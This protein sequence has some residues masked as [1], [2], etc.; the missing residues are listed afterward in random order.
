MVMGRSVCSQA[1]GLAHRAKIGQRPHFSFSFPSGWEFLNAFSSIS[2][3]STSGLVS[4]I[5]LFGR[6]CVRLEFE[7]TLHSGDSSFVSFF[8][9]VRENLQNEGGSQHV[10]DG[11]GRGGLTSLSLMIRMPASCGLCGIVHG[12][13]LFCYDDCMG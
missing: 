1:A 8:Y 2:A 6:C 13:F 7:T 11:F 10:S 9:C 4:C 5:D 3:I 12:S